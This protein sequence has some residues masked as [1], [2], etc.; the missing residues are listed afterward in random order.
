MIVVIVN[1]RSGL[2]NQLFQLNAVL[3]KIEIFDKADVKILININKFKS[4][5]NRK[6]DL[7]FLACNLNLKKINLNSNSWLMKIIRK[8]SIVVKNDNYSATKV[9]DYRLYLFTDFFINQFPSLITQNL[10][11]AFILKEHRFRFGEDQIAIHIR[12]GDFISTG[13][14]HIMSINYY[15]MGIRAIMSQRQEIKSIYVFSDSPLEIVGLVENISKNLSIPCVFIG[16]L[17]DNISYLDEFF[18]MSSASNLVIANST[19]SYWAALPYLSKER[20]I[21]TPE[22]FFFN[23]SDIVLSKDWLKLND[24]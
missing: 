10:I 2:G 23:P 3:K 9:R 6:Y 11:S 21:V 24:L 7:D 18:I 14:Y 12:R 22:N 17:I 19:F 13:N 20:L 15:L 5:Y 8:F 4:N 1:L 16:D